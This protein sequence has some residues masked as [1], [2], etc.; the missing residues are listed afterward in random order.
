MQTRRFLIFISKTIHWIKEFQLRKRCTST[1]KAI[2]YFLFRIFK[3]FDFLLIIGKVLSSSSVAPPYSIR[4]LILSKWVKTFQ[5]YFSARFQ[6]HDFRNNVFEVLKRVTTTW[7]DPEVP[8]I[9]K[10]TLTIWKKILLFLRV[11]SF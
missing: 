3:H 10:K 7:V 6:K 8:D 1:R 2:T 9:T 5:S 11:V 4:A